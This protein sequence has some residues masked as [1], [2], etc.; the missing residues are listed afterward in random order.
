LDNLGTGQPSL[1]GADANTTLVASLTENKHTNMLNAVGSFLGLVT[2]KQC[3]LLIK[4]S[5]L[6][7]MFP[8]YHSCKPMT[9]LVS[10]VHSEK[11]LYKEKQDGMA[12]AQILGLA[13]GKKKKNLNI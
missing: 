8:I 11:S 6:R 2:K 4:L 5:I 10:L 7:V 3:G 1:A 13:V 9:L 12:C